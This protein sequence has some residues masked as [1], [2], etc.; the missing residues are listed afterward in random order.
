MTGNGCTEGLRFGGWVGGVRGDRA[1]VFT[2]VVFRSLL[3]FFFFLGSLV[4][5]FFE[6]EVERRKENTG[7]G[8]AT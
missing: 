5:F 1:R 4:F 7:G 2:S 6:E 8:G 3:F